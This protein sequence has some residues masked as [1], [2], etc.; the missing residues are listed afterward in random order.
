K[1]KQVRHSTEVPK[2]VTAR[3]KFL[4]PVLIKI[5]KSMDEISL[6]VAP[7][8]VFEIALA[9]FSIDISLLRSYAHLTQL[10]PVDNT[11]E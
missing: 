7:N 9:F 5:V 4:Y 3:I 8:G 2:K 11:T 6:Q 1:Q 10:Q